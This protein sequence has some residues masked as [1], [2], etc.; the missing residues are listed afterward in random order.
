MSDGP[1]T[2]GRGA[3]A[4]AP[5]G[6]IR[7]PLPALVSLLAL[8]LLTAI[9]WWRVLERPTPTG[10]AAVTCPVV[11]AHTLPRP[12][13]LTVTVLNSTARKGLAKSVS[14]TLQ[15]IGFTVDIVGNDTGHPQIAGVGE[16][17]YGPD[18][19]DG[20][21]VLQYYF[22]GAT[23]VALG[24]TSAGKLIVSLGATFKTVATNLQVSGAM[25]SANV[26]FAPP[27][28]SVSTSGC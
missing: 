14:T 11:S 27:A 23:E 25:Q 15:K 20:A 8:T 19:K 1:T 22:P 18:Q 17:R 12:S 2:A 21:T 28:G 10:K 13:T 5:G 9:V 7:R 26:S 4:H 24:S 6:P 16:I 3:P